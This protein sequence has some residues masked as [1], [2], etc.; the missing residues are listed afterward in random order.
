MTDLFSVK[1]ADN[2]RLARSGTILT[3]AAATYNLIR[4]PQYTFVNDVWLLCTV[5]GSSDT[6]DV[7]FIGNGES[8]DP[9]YFLDRTYALVNATGIGMYRATQDTVTSFAGKWFSDASGII[10]LTVG[11]TQ[12]TGSFIVFVEYSVIH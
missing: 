11:T 5:A 7:G 2:Y 1:A 3:P 8:A 10:T 12:T 6:I 4:L 9:D